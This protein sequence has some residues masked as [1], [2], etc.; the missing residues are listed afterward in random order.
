MRQRTIAQRLARCYLAR[1]DD[2]LAAL[3]S[4]DALAEQRYDPEFGMTLAQYRALCERN[5]IHEICRGLKRRSGQLRLT[6]WLDRPFDPE[7]DTTLGELL[8]DPRDPA[9]RTRQLAALHLALDRLQGTSWLVAIAR[10]YGNTV[11]AIAAKL[12]IPRT[13]FDR[14]YMPIL[15]RL[16]QEVRHA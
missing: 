14:R 8:C 15:A 3:R 1:E 16:I 10:I 5:A 4:A 12:G 6:E 13:T 9:R 11:S 2:I 7:S